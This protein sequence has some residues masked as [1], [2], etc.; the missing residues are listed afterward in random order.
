MVI[1]WI[2]LR[3]DIGD[4]CHHIQ[5]AF[6]GCFMKWG[7]VAVCSTCDSW[8]VLVALQVVQVK[9]DDIDMAFFDSLL[10]DG[11]LPKDDEGWAAF[12]WAAF[13]AKASETIHANPSFDEATKRKYAGPPPG[14]IQD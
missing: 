10:A 8:R 14:Q 9:V 6:C 12:D 1:L 3:Q 13:E 7:S 4:H 2:L 11:Q 5:M